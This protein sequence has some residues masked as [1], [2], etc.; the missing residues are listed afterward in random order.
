M[1]LTAEQIRNY[2]REGNEIEAIKDGAHI[3][4]L[5][6]GRYFTSSVEGV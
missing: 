2:L 5:K 1:K 6:D 3:I 4:L